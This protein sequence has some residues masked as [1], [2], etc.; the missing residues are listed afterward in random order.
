MNM[1]YPPEHTPLFPLDCFGEYKKGNP[2]CA[3]HCALRLRCA[4]EQDQNMRL[5]LIE[6]LVSA[7]GQI[8]KIQ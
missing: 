8:I 7:E 4:I 6:D 5:E 3:R 1:T 2:L